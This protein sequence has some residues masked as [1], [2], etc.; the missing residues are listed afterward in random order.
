[1]VK[2]PLFLSFPYLLGN[3][4]Q[5]LRARDCRNAIPNSIMEI[6]F[7]VMGLE[8]GMHFCLAASVRIG[9]GQILTKKRIKS[10]RVPSTMHALHFA[11]TEDGMRSHGTRLLSPCPVPNFWY[12][13][14]GLRFC[15]LSSSCAALAQILH[16]FFFFFPCF[17][18]FCAR[19]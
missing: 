7:S 3:R 15:E 12:P 19:G 6:Y 8:A 1:M 17:P 18:G 4:E 9:P 10:G 5:M 2:V 13:I 11:C 16:C 14:R